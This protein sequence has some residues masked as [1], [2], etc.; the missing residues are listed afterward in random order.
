MNTVDC[1]TTR[2]S[3]YPVTL[4]TRAH[5]FAADVTPAVGST[6]S[7]PGPHDYFDA[8]L[9]AC[10]ALTATWY[11]KRHAIPL[12]RVE[13]HVERDDAK[14]RT[15]LYRLRVR[16]A[17]HGPL[18]DEQRAALHRAASACPIHKLMTTSDVEIETV[19]G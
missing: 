14:E 12:E 15:G 11:A 7:A 6:D 4:H 19:E 1:E 13:T 8:A 9:A 16:I 5:S 3:E 10:K 17:F 18:S 2:A